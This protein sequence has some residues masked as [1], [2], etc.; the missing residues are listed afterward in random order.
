M[1]KEIALIDNVSLTYD[2]KV[3]L[4]DVSASFSSHSLYFVTGPSGAGKS[5]L[6]KLL[7]MALTPTEGD[8]KLF[9][10]SVFSISDKHLYQFRQRIGVIFQEHNLIPHMSVLD[11]VLLP[12]KIRGQNLQNSEQNAINLLSWVGLEKYIHSTPSSLSGGQKQRVAIARAVIFNPDVI[13]ADEPTG[14]VDEEMAKRLLYLF[15]NLKKSGTCII[16]ATHNMSLTQ[17]F[18]GEVLS[19]S[20]GRLIV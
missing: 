8:V 14:S 3:A 4:K 7:Y 5:S 19:L 20:E 15:D 2:D 12:L 18:S 13:I 10:T 17:Q 6:L 11:N 16:M 9:D 1:K